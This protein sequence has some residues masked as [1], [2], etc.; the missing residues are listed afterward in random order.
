MT[1][2]FTMGMQFM[3]EKTGNSRTEVDPAYDEACTRFDD[4]TKRVDILIEDINDVLN[5]IPAVLQSGME[6]SSAASSAIILAGKPELP[7][8][9][10]LTK[11][12]NQIS[13]LMKNDPL[14]K[15]NSIVLGSLM[16]IKKNFEGIEKI[17][18]KRRKCQ[19]LCDAARDDL[20][21]AIKKGKKDKIPSL[22]SNYDNLKLEMNSL[23][24]EFVKQVNF[25]SDKQYEIIQEPLIKLTGISFALLKTSVENLQ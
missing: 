19:L 3:K 13:S 9:E 20:D 24:E 11:T 21:N 25:L 5:S 6:F 22:T 1:K 12:F 17:R 14:C 23:T 10:K 4:L 15:S 8:N 2:F 16:S 18:E 7:V